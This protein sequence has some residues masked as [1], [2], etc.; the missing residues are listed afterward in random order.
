MAANTGGVASFQPMG[1]DLPVGPM[2][3]ET[4][5]LFP[6]PVTLRGTSVNVV[7]IDPGR[8]TEDLY[9]QVATREHDALW[10]YLF[11][12]PFEDRD[13]FFAY[14]TRR[15]AST[16]PVCFA[17]VDAN[18]EKAVGLSTLMRIVREGLGGHL[19]LSVGF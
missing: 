12:G 9:S 10:P 6:R 11:D 7:P 16:D 17:I 1:M 19:K 3:D 13:A 18:T 5:A 2:V 8:H 15:S 4:E 14:L